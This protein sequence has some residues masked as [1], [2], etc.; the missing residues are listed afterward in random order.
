MALTR[1]TPGSIGRGAEKTAENYL[2]GQGLTLVQRNF[3]GRRGEIDLIMDDGDILVF[4]EVRSR[5]SGR[6]GKASETIDAKKQA[7]LIR[8]AEQYLAAGASIGDQRANRICRF[9]TVAFDGDAT[10]EN[11]LWTRNAFSA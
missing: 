10:L 1:S 9:D 3:H 6:F 8:T 7:K 5:Q 4:V 2:V 11:L